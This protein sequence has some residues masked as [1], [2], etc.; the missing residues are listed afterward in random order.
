MRISSLLAVGLIAASLTAQRSVFYVDAT[1]G[2]DTNTGTSLA[3]AWKTLGHASRTVG[4]NAT[5]L[6]QPGVYKP[7][8]Q[9]AWGAAR[10]QSNTWVIGVAG[11]SKTIVDGGGTLGNL[12]M[13]RIRS[14]IGSKGIRISGLTFRNTD[15]TPFWSMAIRM[16]STSG[17][18]WASVD[19]EVDNC[20]FD[21]V[22]RGMVIFGST[23]AGQSTGNRIH[24]NLFLNC[25]GRTVEVWGDGDNAIYNNTIVG[26]NG[27]G[28][29]GIYID[30]LVATATSK[31][32]ILNNLV[33]QGAN[34]GIEIG[35]QVA[36]NETTATI[37]DNNCFKN[38]TDYAGFKKL[39]SSNTAVDPLFVDATKRD[40][41]LKPTSPLIDSGAAVPLVRH[42]PDYLPGNISYH[43]KVRAPDVGA[44]ELSRDYMTV[45]APFK[46]GKI[47]QARFTGAAGGVS[48][49]LWSLEQAAISA[50]FGTI[51]I[52]PVTLLP[53]T[54][55]GAIPGIVAQPFPNQTALKGIRLVIQGAA[56][57]SGTLEMLN[58][59]EQSL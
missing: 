24:N 47:G 58:I 16:G 45:T 39:S 10:D 31:A 23:S 11:P 38:K 50:P 21:G 56:I 37:A 29:A 26:P 30:S 22:K 44:Y 48:V 57:R 59:S 5:V 28:G 17:G 14:S 6:V 18:Q 35:T 41:R 51:L 42:D 32:R 15:N 53:I 19:A 33:V 55:V 54:R 36:G 27:S 12:G 40:Y 2:L 13:M 3:R 7:T 4:K 49:L 9:V 20:V 43:G 46:A 8:A 34:S 52:D 25:S 1:N